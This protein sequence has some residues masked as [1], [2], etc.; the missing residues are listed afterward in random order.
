M[1]RRWIIGLLVLVLGW[2]GAS[3][4]GLD[5]SRALTQYAHRIW[6]ATQ[7]LPEGTVYCVQQT[8]DGY[9]WLGTLRGLVRFDGVRFTR[10]ESIGGI[11]LGTV[12][13]HDKCEDAAGT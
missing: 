11:S 13:I 8:R 10:M 2:G 12:P 1:M 5:S 7:G 4:F 9:L 3:A 6:Q